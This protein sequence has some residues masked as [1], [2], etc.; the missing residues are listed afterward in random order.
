MR[1]HESIVDLKDVIIR[2][3]AGFNYL[4]RLS[5]VRENIS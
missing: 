1:A 2:V 4:K 5:F 3:R